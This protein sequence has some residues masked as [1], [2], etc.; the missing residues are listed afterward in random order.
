MARRI[1]SYLLLALVAAWLV[2]SYVPT[3]VISLPPIFV[4]E[5]PAWFGAAALFILVSMVLIQIGLLG[6]TVRFVR[7]YRVEN[8]RGGTRSERVFKLRLNA[9]LF[10]TLVPLLIVLI[11]GLL[12]FSI[13]GAAWL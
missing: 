13:W 5:T 11:L 4:S 3:S 12:S 6:A 1:L 8:R 9:E 10:W 2:L 7:T